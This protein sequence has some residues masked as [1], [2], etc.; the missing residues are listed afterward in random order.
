M[1]VGYLYPSYYLLLWFSLVVG[2]IT[3]LLLFKTR[4]G[5][6]HA[7]LF[8]EALG[9][10]QVLGS[11]DLGSVRGFLMSFYHRDGPGRKPYDPVS[12]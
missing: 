2:L 8:E 7:R 5:I 11:L 9:F 12:V 6:M 3:W 4:T 10:K 1:F